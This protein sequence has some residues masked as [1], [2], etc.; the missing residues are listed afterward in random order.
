[1]I[2]DFFYSVSGYLCTYSYMLLSCSKVIL[3]GSKNCPLGV[4][5]GILVRGLDFGA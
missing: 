1:M 4:G 3:Y 5:I 2:L